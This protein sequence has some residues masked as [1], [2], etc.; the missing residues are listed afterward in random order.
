[1]CRNF[2]PRHLQ[3]TKHNS[4]EQPWEGA[5]G[6]SSHPSSERFSPEGEDGDGQGPAGPTLP[7]AHQHHPHSKRGPLPNVDS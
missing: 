7:S 1:M 3:C 2:K 4:G 5:L 6:P